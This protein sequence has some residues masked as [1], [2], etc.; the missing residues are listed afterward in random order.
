MRLLSGVVGVIYLAVLLYFTFLPLS[1][2]RDP[3]ERPWWVW[4]Q[5]Q[6]FQ[7]LLEDPIGLLLNVTLFIPL[8]ALAPLLLRATTLWRTAVTGLV[9]SGTIEVLQFLGDVT[10][11]PGRIADVDDLIT[12]VVGSILGYLLLQIILLIPA[13]RKVAAN[14][15]WPA[16]TTQQRPPA[17]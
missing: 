2:G 11:T 14:A 4:V 8:G 6:P 1:V 13:L 16:P 3:Y 17:A 10:V 5:L 15:S 9:V 7:D 12:N